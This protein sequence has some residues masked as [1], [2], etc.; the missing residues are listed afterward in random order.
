VTQVSVS[1]VDDDRMLLDGMTAW[2]AA[3]PGL[4]VDHATATVDELLAAGSPT[5]VVLLDLMLADGS[6]PVTNVRR[7][8]EAGH[9]VLVMSVMPRWGHDLDVVS[10]G[11]A[12]Y[13][14]KDH[15]LTTLATAI[16]E[17]A[18]TGSTHSPELAFAWSRDTRPNR[19]ALSKQERSVLIAYATGM[20][21]TAAAR[22]AGV[23]PGT[24]KTYLDRIKAKYQALGRA[25]YTKL[26]L[27]Q[28]VRED[29]L[30]RSPN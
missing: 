13:L 24:A 1:V 22:Q 7:L 17:I 11:A 6:D 18:E 30:R 28:R 20:T 27:A 8:V 25:T 21:L 15:A 9:R 19:P 12:G 16:R 4:R 23:A 14:S 26:D 2:F 5:D 10:A 3:D 29:G